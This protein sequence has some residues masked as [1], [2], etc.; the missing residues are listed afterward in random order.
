MN[1]GELGVVAERHLPA[2]LAFLRQ[3][4]EVNSFTSNASGVQT[5]AELTAQAFASLGLDSEL[6]PCGL[7]GTGPHL[8]SCAGPPGE[9]PVLLVTHSDTVYP[10]D[11]E[12]RHD[13]HWHE[14]PD[15]GRIE[16]PGVIDN[17]GGT[18]LI[19]LTLKVLAEADP[20][21]FRRTPW[22]LAVNAAEEITG[23]DF[24][25]T[26]TAQCG[27]RARAV[28]VFESGPV[29][30]GG[31]HIVTSRKG[32]STWKLA[33]TGRSAHSGSAHG[34]IFFQIHWLPVSHQRSSRLWKC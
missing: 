24:G 16:G 5:V 20:A 14:S 22:L 28:L 18:A 29:V 21:R 23:E 6:Q 32:R 26:V 15:E 9:A 34:R 7:P 8:F 13:F 31:W 11:E 27:G 19:W 2:A 12:Q 4:V 25:K 1:P 30:D 10:P 17:K 3:L 33:A